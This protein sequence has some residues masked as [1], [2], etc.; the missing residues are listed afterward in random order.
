MFIVQSM[1]FV[2]IL[3]KLGFCSL[4]GILGNPCILVCWTL[5]NLV[6]SSLPLWGCDKLFESIFD[7]CDK[8]LSVEPSLLG[9]EGF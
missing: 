9:I 4:L 8:C 1:V 5:E 7:T 6:I 2:F 3:L